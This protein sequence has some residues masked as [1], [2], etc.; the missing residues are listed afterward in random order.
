MSVHED[1]DVNAKEGEGIDGSVG[2]TDLAASQQEKGA[3]ST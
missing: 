2:A 3:D 1:E